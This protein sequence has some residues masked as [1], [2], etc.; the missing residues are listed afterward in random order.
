[1]ENADKLK[2]RETPLDIGFRAYKVA[3]SIMRDVY[4]SP[5]DLKQGELL[6]LSD[7][8]REDKKP[9]DILTSVILDLGLTLDLS[10]K[11]EKIDKNTIFNVDDGSLVACFD[12][13]IDFNV[14]DEIAKMKPLKVVFRDAS[15]KDDKDRINVETKF[16]Q[17]SPDT[18]IKVI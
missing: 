2:E 16:K 9:E 14:I 17:L 4:K 3:D 18:N 1:E 12:K 5:N 11:E 8:I 13:N 6:G 10:I 15:F 7:N